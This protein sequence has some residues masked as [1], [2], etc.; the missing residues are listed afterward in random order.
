MSEFS[1]PVVLA[2]VLFACSVFYA[3]FRAW[4]DEYRKNLANEDEVKRLKRLLE[5]ADE[6]AILIA[7][8][9]EDYE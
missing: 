6:G 8:R 2:G 3:C 9:N 4:L 1:G 7:I 5:R